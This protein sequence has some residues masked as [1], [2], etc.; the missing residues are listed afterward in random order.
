MPRPVLLVAVS[1]ALLAGGCGKFKDVL[2]PPMAEFT[3][4]DGKWK[5]LFPGTPSEKTKSAFGVNFT[6]WVK[7]PWGNKGGYMVGTAE[8]PLSA[9][10]PLALSQKRLDDAVAGSVQG[11]GGKT[12]DTKRVMLHDRYPGRECLASV[13]DPKAGKYRC[14]IFLAGTRMYMVA[15]MGVDEFVADPKADEF[16]DSFALLG[17]LPAASGNPAER[18][19]TA[20]PKR[21]NPADRVAAKAA[22]P[23]PAA[24][25]AG[26]AIH[27]TGGKFKA[28]FPASPTK[29]TAD[30]D[31]HTFTTYAVTAAGGRYSAGYAD[32]SELEGVAGK[33]RQAALDHLRDTTV[34]ELGDGSKLG[35]CELLVLGGRHRGWEFEAT[36]GDRS[37]RGRVYVVGARLYRVTVR[38]SDAAVRD[39]GVADFFDSF[40]LVN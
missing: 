35:K 38:G 31:G 12:I 33:A 26:T 24:K 4:P 3:S 10:E 2:N 20:T 6:M 13:T 22:D 40:Q 19:A 39:P 27:S 28:R 8:L 34:A 15:V 14:R 18:L 36:A 25:A 37:L 29:G 30:A 1:A 7:E 9:A 32:D 16:L 17:D 11:V 21:T 5:A 23:E